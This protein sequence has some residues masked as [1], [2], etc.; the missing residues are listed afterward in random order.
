MSWVNGISDVNFEYLGLAPETLRAVEEAGYT[1]PTPIQAQAIPVVLQGRDVLG[2]AQTGT[3]K[4]ASF[5]LPMIDI[6]SQGRARARMPRSL[7][8]EPTRELAAQV[9]EN[10]EIYGKYH[11]L[12]MAL[13]IGGVSFDD[14]E[15]KLDRGVDVLIATPGRLLDHFG[16]GKL[17]MNGVDILVIDEADRMLDMGFIPDVERICSLITK[18]HQTLFFSATMPREIQN[19]VSKFLTDPKRIEVAPPSSTGANIEQFLVPLN[20]SEAGAKRA[21]LR[22]LL[23]S[24]EVKNAIVFCNR[25]RDVDVVY[26]SLKK[27]GFNAAA[28]H[29]DLDQGSRMEVLESFKSGTVQ[30][31]VASDVAARGLD[32]P[33]M[34]HVFNYDVPSHAEDYIH[35]IGRTGRAGRSGRTFMLSTPADSKWLRNV[36]SLIGKPIGVLGTTTGTAISAAVAVPVAA[37]ADA[38][39]VRAEAGDEKR[40]KRR[41]RR[42]G[43]RGTATAQTTEVTETPME[44]PEAIEQQ[45]VQQQATRMDETRRNKD[46]HR[47]DDRRRDERRPDRRQSRDGRGERR[48]REDDFEP[49]VGLGDHVPEFLLRTFTIAPIGVDEDEEETD[50]LDVDTDADD[51]VTPETIEAVAEPEPE[52]EAPAAEASQPTASKPKRKRKRR[53]AKPVAGSTQDEPAE[54]AAAAEDTAPEIIADAAPEQPASEP[55]VAAEPAA[56]KPR[57][58][59][60]PAAPRTASAAEAEPAQDAAAQDPAPSAEPPAAKPKRARKPAAKKVADA[61]ASP[62]PTVADTA[63][64]A[65]TEAAPA[66]PKRA[67]K[68]AA[69]KAS[70]AGTE[71]D[72]SS[73]AD[74]KP[75]ARRKAPAKPRAPRKP[76]DDTV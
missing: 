17:M 18:K 11:K 62:E 19:L 48:Y 3:G 12:N 76:G 10:F 21:K 37:A 40:G 49:V 7:I 60:K 39:T 44:Q 69:K 6:L 33:S 34:S 63:P 29:G 47:G 67:R 57:R 56:R 4:T 27:H 20:T 5:T 55:A 8:L 50:F 30:L 23:R 1:T 38:E 41:R 25:K 73:D 65:T 75:K 43:D 46:Q 31:L 45:P 28:L 36:Q 15:R 16:R 74:A 13:L 24:E 72:A 51:I 61:A 52:P 59:R 35:R 66:K 14:Q 26:R 53:S 71:A 64:P 2:I 70:T 32:I 58:A 22:D 42:K 68:P 54:V 9:A